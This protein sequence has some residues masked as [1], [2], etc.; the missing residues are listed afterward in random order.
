MT[1][2]YIFIIHMYIIFIISDPEVMEKKPLS[3]KHLINY[4]Y[5]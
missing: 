1:Y 5:T 3:V 2:I 4:Y